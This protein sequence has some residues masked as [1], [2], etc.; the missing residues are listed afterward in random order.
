MK[1]TNC[2]N[3]NKGTPLL[4]TVIYQ[5]KTYC[6]PC[7]EEMSKVS[8]IPSEEICGNIDE[9]V[10]I[11]CG[12]DNGEMDLNIDKDL[13]LC[14]PCYQE[15]LNTPF[16]KGIKVFLTGVLIVVLIGMIV[17]LKYF[18]AYFLIRS[19]MAAYNHGETQL[20]AEKMSKASG[21][22]PNVIA[23]QGILELYNGYHNLSIENDSKALKHFLAYKEILPDEE[24][25]DILIVYAEI[26]VAFNERKYDEMYEKTKELREKDPD[27]AMFILSQASGA[28]CMYV[29]TLDDKYRTE[30]EELIDLALS[31]ADRD[32]MDQIEE[33]I[34]RI[35]HRIETLEIITAMEYY[36]RYPV[37][38]GEL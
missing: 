7:I 29:T 37:E 20:A 1:K 3:C 18:D 38:W 30:S 6:N 4:E 27:S 15:L 8:E 33:Y 31:K 2:S 5:E 25:I 10:C 11:Q 16:P 26:G 13:P 36:K 23:A 32:E 34:N 17:N 28:A 9:T 22:V 21:R 14:D 35:I 24:F 12:F 19:G